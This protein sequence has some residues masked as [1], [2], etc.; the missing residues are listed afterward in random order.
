[1]STWTVRA[2]PRFK[3][4]MVCMSPTSHGD[5]SCPSPLLP[6]LS[7]QPLGAGGRPS[8]LLPWVGADVQADG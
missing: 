8:S 3:D 6:P 5:L 7:A 4:T 1:M 2:E